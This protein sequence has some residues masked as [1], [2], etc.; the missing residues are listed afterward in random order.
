MVRACVGVQRLTNKQAAALRSLRGARRG[1]RS[2]ALR[3]KAWKARYRESR[4]SATARRGPPN[5]RYLRTTARTYLIA[6]AH[7]PGA[8]TMTWWWWWWWWFVTLGT[9]LGTL[10]QVNGNL[11][12]RYGWG[13]ANK[14][15][16]AA[17][18]AAA[19]DDDN[20]RV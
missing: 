16:A 15:D 18:A 20:D 8:P 14:R 1:A 9:L 7:A 12:W 4:C 2:A 6:F 17:A 5:L 19:D 10:L 11:A 13:A 3:T